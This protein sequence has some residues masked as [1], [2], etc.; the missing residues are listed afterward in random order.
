LA[1]ARELAQGALGDIAKGGDPAARKRAE[2]VT[3][4]A[5]RAEI[6]DLV[7]TVVA[8]FTAIYAKK[9]R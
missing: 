6:D 3:A 7:E 4:R 1:T 2:R 9:K 8:D 5:V